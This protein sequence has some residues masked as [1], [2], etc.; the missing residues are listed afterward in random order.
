M[1]QRVELDLD[2]GV[3]TTYR[4]IG[5]SGNSSVIR[6][7]PQILEAASMERGDRIKLTADMDEGTITVERVEAEE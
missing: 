2:E 3:A 6:I 7:P 4:S 1:S 5:K